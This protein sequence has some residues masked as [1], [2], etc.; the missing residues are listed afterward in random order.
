MCLS[1]LRVIV[2]S[3]QD[4]RDYI[5]YLETHRIPGRGMSER[6]WLDD[7]YSEHF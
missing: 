5:A 1:V 2:S 3:F 7:R 6:E 4:A